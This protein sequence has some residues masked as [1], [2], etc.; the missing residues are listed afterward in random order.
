[1]NSVWTLV[2]GQGII[3]SHGSCPENM[4]PLA[5]TGY[6]LLRVAGPQG[7]ARHR[8]DG[9]KFVVVPPVAPPDVSFSVRRHRD[10][11]LTACDWTQLPDVPEATQSRYQTY[12]QALRDVPDQPGFP[13]AIQWPEQP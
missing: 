9:G 6:Q 11:L 2:D 10:A 3:I 5:P 4:V 13:T 7:E 1:M 8:R 12:R